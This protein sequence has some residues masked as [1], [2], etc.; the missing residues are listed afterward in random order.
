MSLLYRGMT[1]VNEG[2]LLYSVVPFS[3]LRLSSFQPHFICSIPLHSI[4]LSSLAFM[5]MNI[6]VNI[7]KL[8]IKLCCNFHKFFYLNHQFS[9]EHS[10]FCHL[11]VTMMMIIIITFVILCIKGMFIYFTSIFP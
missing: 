11:V 6:V 8:Q 2:K 7:T 4:A 3:T 10:F 5:F 9:F 1:A